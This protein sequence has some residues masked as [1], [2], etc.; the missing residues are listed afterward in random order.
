MGKWTQVVKNLGLKEAPQE[1][2]YQIKVEAEKRN[3]IDILTGGGE[4]ASLT[5]NV[6]TLTAMLEQ[7]R[8][9][10]AEAE[11]KPSDKFDPK[12][13]TTADYARQMK[14]A[15]EAKDRAEELKSKAEIQIE[16]IRQLMLPAYEAEGI[17]KVTLKNGF[18]FAAEVEPYSS[19]TSEEI[20]CPYCNDGTDPLTPR[21]ACKFC[22]G[23][24]KQTGKELFRRFCLADPDLSQSMS[25]AWQ[26]QNALVKECLT[27]GEEPP[28]GIKL[29]VKSKIVMRKP[30]GSSDESE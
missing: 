21:D 29:F 1:S 20:V 5:R 12:D 25:L 15:R 24:G 18:N 22:D 3:V 7:A 16:A 8:E 9:D 6:E 30:R 23:K 28:P 19:T 4:V 10:L 26:T 14:I 27:K 11:G 13:L 17:Q 2:A